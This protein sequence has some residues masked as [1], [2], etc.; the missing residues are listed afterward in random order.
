MVAIY[1]HAKKVLIWIG[2]DDHDTPLLDEMCRKISSNTGLRT[3][4]AQTHNDDLVSLH[5]MLAFNGTDMLQA[6]A[7]REALVRFLSRTC[8]A[9]FAAC[10]L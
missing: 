2:D 4:I 6:Q 9:I 10:H 3:I 8:P 1:K 7:R 5:D